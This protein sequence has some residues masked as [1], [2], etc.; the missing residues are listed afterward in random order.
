MIVKIGEH[1]VDVKDENCRCR[2]CYS[3]GFDKGTFVQG[4]GYTHYHKKPLPVCWTRHLNGC[5]HVSVCPQCRTLQVEGVLD[6]EKC[7]V[8]TVPLSTM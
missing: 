3:L 1:R 8:P 5:P 7:K 4:M 2:N 6:C